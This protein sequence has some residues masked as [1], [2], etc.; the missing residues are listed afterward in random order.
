VA[1]LRS[2]LQLSVVIAQGFVRDQLLL[3][4]HAL[5]YLTLLSIVPLLAIAVALFDLLGGSQHVTRLLVEQ[6]AAGAP[7]A[8]DWILDVVGRVQFG[9]L[10]TL[11]GAVLILTT[12]LAV[13]NVGQ[14]LNAIWGVTQQ[15]P[16]VRRIPDYL[17]VVVVSPL[18]LGAALSLGASLDSQWLVQKLLQ[19]P[20][21]ATLYDAGLRQAPTVLVV[22]GL[23]FVYWFLP[24]TE[25]RF[26][27][28]LLGG[29]V[30]GL[31]FSV[32]QRAYVQLNVGVA[33]YDAIFAG[34]AWFPL[35]LAWIYVE[36]AIA[37]LGAEVAY[38]YQTLPLYRRE[39]RGTPAGPAARESV[40]LAVALS[41]ARAFR[42]GSAPWTETTLS[43]HLDVP[44]RTVR[45]VIAQL[46]KAGLVAPVAAPEQGGV[47]QLGRPADRIRV[48]Q[49]LE[50]LRGP[51]EA[52]LGPKEL[53]SQ[54]DQVLAE[55]DARHREAGTRTLEE[56]LD[57]R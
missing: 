55:L 42:E 38:A 37:L 23:S 43:E 29:T 53:A 48:A 18:L 51:R 12:V 56:L 8:V 15:R 34:F 17:A 32:A 45:E 44:V 13:G 54:V 28:A 31:L 6:F 39:V 30:A 36:W 5:T 19:W 40:G 2:L 41:I 14:A 49:V 10:G 16:W 4:A 20:L 22:A 52:P 57:E 25:V 9:A 50:A 3:R 46:E 21:F 27:S 33:R 7:D 1:W 47:W 11:G 26:R 35:L 24:N